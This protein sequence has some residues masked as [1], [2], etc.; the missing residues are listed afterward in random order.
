MKEQIIEANEAYR[1]GTPIMSDEEY[2]ILLTKYEENEMDYEECR[3]FKES[4]FE[5]GGDVK[6]DYIVGSLEKVRYGEHELNKFLLVNNINQLIV[7]EKIDGCSF[8]A[9]YNKGKF[10]KGATRGDGKT[11]KDITKKLKHILPKITSKDHLEIRGELTLTHNSHKELGF[12]NRRNGTV[13]V[14]NRDEVNPE[15]I[16]HVKAIVYQIVNSDKGMFDQFLELEQL[17]FQT[18]LYCL[19]EV[20]D[21]TEENLKEFLLERKAFAVYD[22]DGLVISSFDCENENVYHPKHKVAF[23]VNS[24][25]I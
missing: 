9:T 20:T 2:D 16:K 8:V 23:K 21:Y 22:I 13:G 10:I 11:G 1:K 6:H 19:H 17:G 18:P 25:A 7:S 5:D 12:K 14:I 24:Q 4:L 15:T 3:K